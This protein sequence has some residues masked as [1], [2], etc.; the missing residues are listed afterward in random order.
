MYNAIYDE[1]KQRYALEEKIV[2][3]DWANTSNAILLVSI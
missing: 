3:Q 2:L 1:V